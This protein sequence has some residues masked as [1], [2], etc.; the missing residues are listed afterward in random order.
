VPLRKKDGRNAVIKKKK[1]QGSEN[2]SHLSMALHQ[3]VCM[4]GNYDIDIYFLFFMRIYLFIYYLSV[5]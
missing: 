2:E 4:Y 1:S 5:F 3:Y